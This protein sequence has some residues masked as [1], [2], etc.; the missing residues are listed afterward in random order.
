MRHSERRFMKTLKKIILILLLLPIVLIAVSLFLP[1]R[2]QVEREVAIKAPPE[3]IYPWLAQLS[4][5]P[6][7]TVWNTNMDPTLVYTYSG[8]AEGVGAMMNWTA[9]SGNGSLK[10]TSADVKEGVKYELDFAQG[11]FQCHGGVRMGP[12][13]DGS[14]KVTWL[15]EGSLGWNPV[16]RYFGLFMDKMM[17]GDFLKNLENLKQRAEAKTN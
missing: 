17:G 2:Y 9:K 13:P 12:L 6:D 15:N 5:W 14:T 8:P 4:R 16:S 3:A 1:S 7:W 11:K 10:L